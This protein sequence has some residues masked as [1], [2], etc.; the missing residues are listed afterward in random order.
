MCFPGPGLA[1]EDKRKRILSFFKKHPLIESLMRIPILLDAFCWTWVNSQ[2]DDAQPQTMT[3]LYDKIESGLWEK[4]EEKL[5]PGPTSSHTSEYCKI[6]RDIPHI[7][8]RL[9]FSGIYS[10]VIDFEPTHRRLILDPKDRNEI[11]N[12]L[13]NTDAFDDVLSKLSFIRSSDPSSRAHSSKDKWTYHFLHFTFQE[14]FA[15][16]YFVRQW[17]AKENLEFFNLATGEKIS[18]S[19]DEFLSSNK[20]SARYDIPWRFVAGLLDKEH[21]HN[22]QELERFFKSLD[23]DPL[24]LLGPVHQRLLMHCLSETRPKFPLRT[25]IEAHLS[26]WLVYQCGSILR[27]KNVYS[28]KKL[29]FRTLASEIEFPEN[30]LTGFLKQSDGIKIIGCDSMRWLS[31]IPS[32]FIADILSV[33]ETESDDVTKSMISI[34]NR[35]GPEIPDK[36]LYSIASL[37]WR[38]ADSTAAIAVRNPDLSEGALRLK[39]SYDRGMVCT[40]IGLTLHYRE[41]PWKLWYE[42]AKKLDSMDKIARRHACYVLAGQ[43]MP[44]PQLDEF[45]ANLK[46]PN[47]QTRNFASRVLGC[48]STLEADAMVS[49]EE[50]LNHPDIRFRVSS[51]RALRRQSKLRVEV[52]RRLATMLDQ[53]PVVATAI[54]QILYQDWWRKSELT[55][56]ALEVLV[57]HLVSSTPACKWAV[58]KILDG[59]RDLSDAILSE[60]V[61]KL[62]DDEQKVRSEA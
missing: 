54:L 38:E 59:Q 32:Q 19:T 47:N 45:V 50:N 33:I 27:V 62:D 17:K 14:Y 5:G 42:I 41:L 20:Y 39:S 25:N 22:P 58:L 48:Q 10:N 3:A 9:A 1:E 49:I 40:N 26:K 6:A 16:Q 23:Q 61:K 18:K 31:R 36:I 4:D 37:L 53:E 11:S 21:N 46:S 56:T 12:R 55:K 60:I 29:K 13:N 28:Y 52:T 7:L 24:D 57:R 44:K 35:L 51:I 34:L 2:D 15:A 43:P 30:T 8:Q